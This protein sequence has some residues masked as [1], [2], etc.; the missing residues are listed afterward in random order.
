MDNIEFGKDI[1]Q[2]YLAKLLKENVQ[3]N[4]KIGKSFKKDFAAQIE[5]FIHFLLT[6]SE[7]LAKEKGSRVISDQ[8][9]FEALEE[10]D[11]PDISQEIR[12][13]KNE[14]KITEKI[15]QQKKVEKGEK[16]QKIEFS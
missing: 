8:M 15:P 14:R 5:I 4:I 13:N 6:H 7:E 12:K 9:I 11:H 1:P 10:I 2:S 3:E 16:I